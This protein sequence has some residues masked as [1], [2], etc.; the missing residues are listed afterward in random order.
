MVRGLDPESSVLADRYDEIVA[1]MMSVPYSS[2][3]DGT[4]NEQ[5]HRVPGDWPTVRSLLP[6]R[7]FRQDNLD[8]LVTRR[9]LSGV[10]PA[11]HG[12]QLP[13]ATPGAEPTKA[14]P[15][16]PE[17]VAEALPP[18]GPTP[19]AK[20]R[21]QGNGKALHSLVPSGSI[22]Q[23]A[24]RS[25]DPPPRQREWGSGQASPVP[26]ACRSAGDDRGAN[27]VPSAVLAGSLTV[28]ERE[29]TARS[30]MP[31]PVVPPRE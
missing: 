27:R 25:C 28:R 15:E 11:A 12:V 18:Q 3:D 8:L 16:S 23:D 29:R 31:E 9:T 17:P 19:C 26:A 4:M 7:P 6:D 24:L 20:L 5:L 10:L 13:R 14:P 22:A 21:P 2:L 30:G 1:E